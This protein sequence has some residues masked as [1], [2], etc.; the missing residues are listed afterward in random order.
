MTLR[1]AVRFPNGSKLCADPPF[2]HFDFS[3]IERQYSIDIFG[4][5]SDIYDSEIRYSYGEAQH[6]ALL[7]QSVRPMLRQYTEQAHKLFLEAIDRADGTSVNLSSFLIP[8]TYCSAATTMFGKQFPAE[9]SMPFFQIFDKD[10][11][12]MAAGLPRIVTRQARQAWEKL[13]DILEEYMETV[14]HEQD[15]PEILRNPIHFAR[16]G[17]WVRRPVPFFHMR[18]ADH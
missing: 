1:W 5:P 10:F 18:R 3:R 2:K 6:R 9:K 12:L 11:P 17:K 16:E 13:I 8:P 7:P 15:S 4:V 14:E